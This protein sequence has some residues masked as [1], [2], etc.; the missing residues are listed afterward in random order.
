[1]QDVG[2]GAGD[3]AVSPIVEGLSEAG[4]SRS[5]LEDAAVGPEPEIG[6]QDRDRAGPG[7]IR[8]PDDSRMSV[9]GD[10]DPVVQGIAEVADP[11]LGLTHFEAGKQDTPFIRAEVAVRV[12][13]IEEVR[14][15]RGDDPSVPQGQALELENPVREDHR[16]VHPSVAVPVLQDPDPALG[17]LARRRVVGVVQHLGDEG[18]PLLVE[19]QVHR[20]PHVR[21]GGEDLYPD[22]T[23]VLKTGQRLLR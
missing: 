2:S 18:P 15:R 4:G 22:I 21:F 17:R 6:S 13:E 19:D 3:E 7:P 11:P 12:L 20:V 16:V 1:M 8:R 14:R 9:V 10:V 23:R 5:R